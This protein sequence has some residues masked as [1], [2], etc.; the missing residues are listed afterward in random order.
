M[1]CHGHLAICDHNGTLLSDT[2]WIAIQR[3]GVQDRGGNGARYIL[4]NEKKWMVY[5][6]YKGITKGDSS[7]IQS[8]IR[9][10]E[11]QYQLSL[12]R[13]ATGWCPDCPSLHGSSSGLQPWQKQLLFDSLFRSSI[14][15]DYRIDHSNSGSSC[16]CRNG[17]PLRWEK[18]HGPLPKSEPYKYMQHTIHFHTDSILVIERAGT[19]E[20]YSG[21]ESEKGFYFRHYYNIFLFPDGPRTMTLDSLFTGTE[22]RIVIQNAAMNYLRDHPGIEASCSNPSMYPYILNKLFIMNADGLVFYPPWRLHDRNKKQER[23]TF[24]IPW[25]QLRPYLRK[26]IADKLNLQ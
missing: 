5:D 3:I 10:A 1:T 19:Y 13:S 16:G 15:I 23:I 12:S 11:K 7:L 9:E 18:Q 26:D 21:S 25:S 8:M 17:S 14:A 6:T 4:F 20:R 2:S 22:W 24:L